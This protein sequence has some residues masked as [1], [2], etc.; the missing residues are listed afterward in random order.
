[1]ASTRAASLGRPLRAHLGPL[2]LGAFVSTIAACAPG[3]H[4]LL[5]EVRSQADV[6]TLHVE[7]LRLDGSGPP[8][9]RM[10]RINRSRDSINNE[11]PI[12]IAISFHAPV[13]VV[14]YVRAVSRDTP[15]RTLLATRCYT[16]SG[17]VRDDVLLV[18]LDASVDEDGDGFPRQAT[19]TCRDLEPDG[20]A[21]AS[22][23]K[24]GR[25]RIISVGS[26]VVGT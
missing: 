16:V 11:E 18:Q 3:E 15:P 10:E 8:T 19:A 13:E 4:V 1:M 22:F 9:E 14:V 12:R 21:R 2:A 6:D 17:I 20:E 7:V 25:H 24:K 23:Q 26:N 5:L